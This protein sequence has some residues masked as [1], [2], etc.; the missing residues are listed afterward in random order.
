MPEK[1]IQQSESVRAYSVSQRDVN[2]ESRTILLSFSSETPVE[3]WFG[4]EILDHSQSS[5]RK[6]RVNSAAPLLWN[7]DPDEQIG[8]VES[9]RID[10]D[11]VGRAVVRFSKNPEAEEIFQDV[12]DGIIKNVSV[13]FI[14]YKTVLE[15]TLDGVDTYRTIDWEPVEISMV[16]IPADISV[17]VGRNFNAKKE[18]KNMPDK[19]VDETGDAGHDETRKL[20]APEPEKTGERDLI[21]ARIREIGKRF[22]AA[23]LA[24]DHIA[25]DSTVAEFQAAVRA[26]Q[27]QRLQPV[28]SAPRV[29]VQVPRR[30]G[31]LRAFENNSRGEEA[32][33]RSG[34]WAQAVLFGDES[35]RRW[36]KDYGVRVMTGTGSGTS[37]VVPDEMILPIIDLREQYGVARRYCFVQPMGSDT[38]TIPRRKSGVT[39][40]F[41]GRTDATTESDAE[42]DDIQLVAREVAALTRLSKSYANDA[43]INLAD[44][45]ATE[46]AYAFAVKEDACLFNG[47]GT[48][49][50]GG[51]QGIRSKI[52]SKAGAIAAASG[53]DTFAEIDHDDL[54]NVI[55]AL[56]EYPG[57]VPR[58]FAS[59][60][61]NA[62]V[63]Q[64][65]KTAAGG[66]TIRDLEG[67]Q[68]NEYLGDE[69]VIAQSMPSV[70]TALNAVA[71]LVYGDLRQGVTFGDR[72]GFEIE[73]LRER[74]AEYRQIGIQAVERFDIN[75]HG[76]GDATNPGPIVA[77]IGT[78]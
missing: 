40:Y 41:P 32:A 16:S 7:H 17:G 54:V 75:V 28:P 57:I 27:S 55:G 31:S 10:N 23:E 25:I 21:N 29:E 12:L 74:Y 77:L 5:M 24:E 49:T 65:L 36:C 64:A 58:W 37:V 43:A 2:V 73:V 47:D 13:R 68:M 51:I 34:M 11:R 44:H 20:D 19:K 63:F 59:K 61:A 33:Y 67:R 52:L 46:M 62:L 69:V 22:G 8:V 18:E 56:P 3:E 78:T 35:A 15:S 72:A 4:Y 30:T 60:R 48:S 38:A 76:V 45:L 42:F 39:A 53:H 14:R 70:I 50:Y 6:S 26:S 1:Q 71:M 9:V 66:N